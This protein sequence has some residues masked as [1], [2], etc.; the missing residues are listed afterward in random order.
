[1]FSRCLISAVAL[2]AVSAEAFAEAPAFRVCAEPGNLPFSDLKGAGFENRIAAVIADDL[3]AAL[4]LVPIA[5]HGPGFFRATLGSGRCDALVAMPEGMDAVL[6]TTPYYKSS[7]VFVTRA[8]RKLDIH[9]FDDARLK[10]LSIGVRVVGV[11]PDTPPLAALG[12][13][14][15]IDRLHRYPV[16]G[17]LGGADE[18]DSAE[19]MVRDVAAGRIDLAVMW[20]PAAGYYAAGQ[21]PGLVLQPTPAEDNGISL[22]TSIGMAVAKQN[23]G[24]RDRLNAALIRRQGEIARILADYHVPI[25]P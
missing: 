16:G 10:D 25:E 15:L 20:G 6:V 8:D 1:M 4:E 23:G 13:R 3:G 24:L 21:T 9:G 22:R 18:E 2:L 7:W 11:G 5:Q 14:G 19:R 12:A 17:G